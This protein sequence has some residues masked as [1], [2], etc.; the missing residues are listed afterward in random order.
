MKT[1]YFLM[2]SKNL[3]LMLII[4]SQAVFFVQASGSPQALLALEGK[5]EKESVS[6]SVQLLADPTLAMSTPNY[7]VTAGDVYSLVF[8]SGSTPVRYTLPVDTS[9]KIRVANLG[10]IKCSGFTY[11]QLKSQV[12][13]LIA[14]N[15]PLSGTQF[16]LTNPAVF[17]VSIMGEVK[18]A[19]EE[20]AWALTR[21]SAFISQNMT[22]YSS[23]RKVAVISADG[24]KK[25][26]DLYR[27]WRY[28]DFSQ[29]PYLRPDDKIEICRAE[30][31]V[32]IDGAV[33]RP[34]VYELLPNENLDE[35]IE[36][37]ACGVKKTANLMNIRLVRISDGDERL[38]K[39]IYLSQPDIKKNFALLDRDKISV[40]DW[41]EWQP[42]IELKGIIKKP[43]VTDYAA[44]VK[45]TEST[46]FY[47]TKVN[48]YI[49]EDY[50][51]LIRRIRDMFTLFSDL[52]GLYV[53]RNGQ[54]ILLEADR[55]LQDMNFTSP[56]KVEKNDVV[57][58]P[59]L[60]FFGN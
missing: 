38:E 50:S 19:T 1:K 59:Y 39:V 28:G 30:R 11:N 57:I 5:G 16:V 54:Q 42:F 37:Y 25:N 51:S 45:G 53:E 29:D 14:Q 4:F 21:L 13:Y 46:S 48:F 22:E 52:H 34:G 41:S 40:S 7:P 15:Y 55:I 56:Y 47:K 49:G 12:E 26:F 23:V 43:L 17:L 60:P 58:V 44:D 33:E 2:S 20:K 32:T 27:A 36:S 8:M 10:V 9:Y 18:K 31:K 24:K 35:L 3:F 6:E